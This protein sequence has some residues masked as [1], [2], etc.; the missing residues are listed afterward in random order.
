MVSERMGRVDLIKE[1]EEENCTDEFF[2]VV[3]KLFEEREVWSL[4][5]PMGVVLM[6]LLVL[7]ETLL[8]MLVEERVELEG[9]WEEESSIRLEA[10]SV[11][12]ASPFVG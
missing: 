7:L 8:P 10:K 11:D 4:L 3:F 9:I 1:G 5:M 12:D 2:V 6:M